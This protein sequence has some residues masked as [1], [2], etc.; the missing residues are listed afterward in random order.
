M[1][2]N[3]LCSPSK[4]IVAVITDKYFQIVHGLKCIKRFTK[5]KI[6]PNLIWADSYY[7]ADHRLRTTGLV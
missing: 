5:N 7:T 2:T 6:F 1:Y 4:Q 3:Q